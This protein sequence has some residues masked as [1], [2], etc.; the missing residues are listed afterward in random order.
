[1]LPLFID[2]PMNTPNLLCYYNPELIPSTDRVI[3]VDLCVYGGNAAGCITAIQARKLGLSV[4]LLESGGHVGGLTAGGLSLTDHGR[5][6]VI[7]GLSYEFYQR[8]GAHYGVEEEWYFEPKVAEKVLLDW[9]E[10]AGVEVI[11]RQF[12][13]KTH[14]EGGR[15]TG[16]EL[17]GGL[18]VNAKYFV[19]C[20]HEGDL[21]A[22]AGVSYHVGREDNSV[23][24]ETLNGAHDRHQH[25]FDFPV[26][27]YVIENDPSSGLLPGIEESE[28]VMGKGDDRVQAYNFRMCLSKDPNNQIPFEKPEGYNPAEY[29]LLARVIRGGWDGFL[30][31]YDP[32]RGDKCDM[33]NSGAVSTDFIGR[34]FDYPE[35][36]YATRERIFQEHVTYQKGLMWFR[37][38]DERVPENVKEIWR[39]WQL[40][41]DEFPDCGGWPHQLYVR[42]SR[43]MI[44]DYIVTEADC[45]GDRECDDPVGMGSYTLDS[46]NCR[47]Y[48]KYVDGVAQVRN[49]GDV[50]VKTPPYKISRRSILPRKAECENLSVVYCT[51]ASHIAYGSLRME[52]VFMLLGQSAATIVA[53]ASQS[54]AALQDVPYS[55]IRPALERDGQV[56]EV[57]E[58]HREQ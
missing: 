58:E 32:I 41:A 46:H 4:I 24:G 37:C 3:D 57:P 21:M 20:S 38:N 23:Y 8:C 53:L 40:P 27:P 39:Q 7:G 50:Q 45:R 10:E 17:E 36:D 42:E 55:E 14:K 51:A 34:N 12:L 5:K 25:Q 49:E 28:Y 26:S 13:S 44:S 29:E 9:L 19:D 52:P 48:V 33:N 2:I 47:R 35:G 22:Q 16:I 15:I 43:R 6:Y 54:G 31:K 30:R 1:L 56:L 18:R 11:F